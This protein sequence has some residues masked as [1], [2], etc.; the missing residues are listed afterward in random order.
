[1]PRHQNEKVILNNPNSVFK[2]R[3]KFDYLIYASTPG[4]SIG[5]RKIKFQ[6]E[7]DGRIYMDE[8]FKGKL[9]KNQLDTLVSLLEFSCLDWVK[10]SDYRNIDLGNNFIEIGYN[11]KKIEFQDFQP[12]H[13]NAPFRSLISFL[14]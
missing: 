2:D 6:I 1:K 5:S 8:L 9:S 4:Y 12:N 11:D 10:V 7:N 14:A 3:I 13:W